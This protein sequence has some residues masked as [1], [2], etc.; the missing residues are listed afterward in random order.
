MKQLIK[1]FLE[2]LRKSLFSRKQLVLE[3][4]ARWH[5]LMVYQRNVT[6]P[7][8]NNNDRAIWVLIS[9][10]LKDWKEVLVIV[11]PKTVIKWHRKGFKLY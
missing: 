5:Q 10:F 11:K 9:G 8:L 6:K 7:K 4:L 1:L 3:N 2:T